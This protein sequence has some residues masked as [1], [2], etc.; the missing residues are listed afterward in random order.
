MYTDI[1]GQVITGGQVMESSRILLVPITSATI[2]RPRHAAGRL[3]S[4]S[5]VR[6][7]GED[8]GECQD[9]EEEPVR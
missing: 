5:P 1:F 3:R 4:A 9:G 8:R 2:I 6:E 7:N